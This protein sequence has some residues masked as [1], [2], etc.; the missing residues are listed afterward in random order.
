MTDATTA[1][2]LP[3]YVTTEKVVDLDGPKGPFAVTFHRV[4]GDPFLT[5][6]FAPGSVYLPCQR[7]GGEGRIFHSNLYGGV[8]FTCSGQRFGKRIDGG[9]GKARQLAKARRTREA[10]ARRAR[11]EEARRLAR[12]WESWLDAREGRRALVAELEGFEGRGFL[13]DMA[14]LVA[15]RKPLTER[16][17][18][19]VERT[20]SS[21][22]EE[23]ERRVSAGHYGTPGE[24][25]EL[26]VTVLRVTAHETTWGLSRLVVMET[27]GGHC[28]KTW[29]TGAFG[30]EAERRTEKARESMAAGPVKVRIR[31]TVKA[32]GE[33]NGS[34]E[35]MLT[36][37]AAV[38]WS[39]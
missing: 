33:Y 11:E 18:A 32:H 17:E 20:F 12:E 34:P 21:R 25:V 31:A 7:C 1:T 4:D 36:R 2:P 23:V 26:E 24:K 29:V 39:E 15:N 27:G 38:S 10:T 30:A 6:S 22:K 8:C 35:T 13:A 37:V 9:W 16:Q 19:A 28:V 5:L 3:D 14:E